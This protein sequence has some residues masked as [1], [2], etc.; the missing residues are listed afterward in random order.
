MEQNLTTVMKLFFKM[1]K[2]DEL[3]TFEKCICQFIYLFDND[4]Q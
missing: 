2:D 4:E 3:T 1:M